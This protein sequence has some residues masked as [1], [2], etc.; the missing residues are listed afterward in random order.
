MRGIVGIAAAVAAFT[1]AAAPM[2]K[3]EYDAGKARIAAEYRADRQ[4]CGERH[5]N[6]ADLCIAR[7]RGEQRVARAELD[8]AFKPSPNA[9]LA[10][11]NARAQ[12][13]YA[14]AMQECDDRKREAR[15]GCVKDAKA[16]RERAKAEASAKAAA[17]PR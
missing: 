16:A 13:A 8:A 15:S 5:G 9:N 3:D 10:A 2:T 11:A 4:K 14:I 7:S 1:C 12:A 6:A 17:A